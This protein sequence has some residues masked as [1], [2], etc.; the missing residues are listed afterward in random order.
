VTNRLEVA[1]RL[2]LY[3]GVV[4][5]LADVG[6]D[7]NAAILRVCRRLVERGDVAPNSVI[8]VVSISAD[9]AAGSS[10]FLKLQRV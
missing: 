4:P 9:L 1:R 5:S 3:R 10:N 7:A 2:A 8:V 6:D